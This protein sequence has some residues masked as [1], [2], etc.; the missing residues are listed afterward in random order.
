MADFKPVRLFDLLPQI[1]RVRDAAPASNGALE[2]LLDV[3][4]QQ[5]GVVRDDIRQLWDNLFVET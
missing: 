3:I 2:A 5:V 4:D 1:Y